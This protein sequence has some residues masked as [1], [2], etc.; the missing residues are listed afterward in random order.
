MHNR[1]AVFLD[2]LCPKLRVRRWR[3][4]L[5]SH[6]SKSCIYCGKPS[7]SID[8]IVPQSRGGLSVTENC[9]PACLSC[10]G[11]KSDADAFDCNQTHRR[12][13][14][15][16]CMTDKLARSFQSRSGHLCSGERCDQWIRKVCRNKYNFYSYDCGVTDATF[17]R[18]IWDKVR[19]EKPHPCYASE[20]LGCRQSARFFVGVNVS[21]TAFSRLSAAMITKGFRRLLLALMGLK[22]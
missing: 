9:V 22:S 4:S 19:R 12:L 17:G 6:T 7:E 14:S 16:H 10:N 13:T 11:Q 2:E 5:H 8:H 1:D 18:A 21:K 20:C 3:Q 15:V